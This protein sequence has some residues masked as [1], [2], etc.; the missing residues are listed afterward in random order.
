MKKHTP[1]LFII[2]LAFLG[3][4]TKQNLTNQ[5]ITIENK[6]WIAIRLGDSTIELNSEQLPTMNLSEGQVSGFTSCNRYHGTYAL[7]GSI[8]SFNPPAATKM[9]CID[10]NKTENEFLEALSKTKSWKY[11]DGELY[12]LGENKKVLL[13]FALAG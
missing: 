11:T 10:T 12:F 5:S 2:L 3:C 4:K 9:F 8:L 6:E 13:V 1:I 7:D